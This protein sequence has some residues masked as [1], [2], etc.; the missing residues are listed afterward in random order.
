MYFI[1]N[2]NVKIFNIN[3]PILDV[4]NRRVLIIY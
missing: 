1:Y 2:E 4:D 3:I